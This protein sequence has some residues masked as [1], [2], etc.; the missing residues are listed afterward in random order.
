MESD[1]KPNSICVRLH[2][3]ATS[4]QIGEI[5]IAHQLNNDI[6]YFELMQSPGKNLR[7]DDKGR[8]EFSTLRDQSTLFKS[9]LT[10]SGTIYLICMAHEHKMNVMGQ[11]GWYLALTKEGRLQGN[12]GKHLTSHWFLLPI[13]SEKADAPP[14]PEPMSQS[15]SPVKSPV[16]S[17]E[18]QHRASANVSLYQSPVASLNFSF[19]DCIFLIQSTDN[20]VFDEDEVEKRQESTS[21]SPP[22]FSA[23]PKKQMRWLRSEA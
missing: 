17:P 16:K 1:H 9:E 22:G 3:P 19:D 11:K 10:P 2:H 6:I 20:N 8:V 18:R 15:H 13:E 23:S 5:M 21:T 14:L 12:A 4:N 7:I